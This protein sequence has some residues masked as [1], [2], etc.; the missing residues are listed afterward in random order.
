[1]SDTDW[2]TDA[3]AIAEALGVNVRTVYRMGKT[4][5]GPVKRFGHRYHSCPEWLAR[6]RAGLP[7]FWSALP[8]QNNAPY[9]NPFLRSVGGR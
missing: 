8:Q 2:I 5:T 9:E 7:G 6:Y 3:A 1:M 4:G